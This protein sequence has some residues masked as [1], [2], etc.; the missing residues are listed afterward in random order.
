[1]LMAI[2][3]NKSNAGYHTSHRDA[4]I[5]LSTLSLSAVPELIVQWALF[6]FVFEYVC[7]VSFLKYPHTKRA[8]PFILVGALHFTT[9]NNTL[10][11]THYCSNAW[12]LHCLVTVP[13]IQNNRRAGSHWS[14]VQLVRYMH[15]VEG[16]LWG[17]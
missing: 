12:L 15:T 6:V 2:D 8:H 9:H 17:D 11:H 7:T 4:I 14:P 5:D 13:Y 10:F 1:M 16:R 3:D